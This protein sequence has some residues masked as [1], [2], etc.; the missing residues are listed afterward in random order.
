M[1]HNVPKPQ[2]TAITLKVWEISR[3]HTRERQEWLEN[4]VINKVIKPNLYET[5]VPKQ[6]QILQY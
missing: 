5:L 1:K 2:I 3:P 6:S 4:K